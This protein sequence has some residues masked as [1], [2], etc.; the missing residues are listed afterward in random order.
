MIKVNLAKR[1]KSGFTRTNMTGGGTSSIKLSGG[2]GDFIEKM[3]DRFSRPAQSIE[4]SSAGGSKLSIM[5]GNPIVKLVFS[6]VMVYLVMETLDG[7][8][9]TEVKNVQ[10]QIDKSTAESM[11]LT[12]RLNEL[13]GYQELKNKL[14][15]DE[16]SLKTKLETLVKLMQD[17]AV[18]PK[19]LLQL[20][21]VLPDECWITEVKINE[22]QVVFQGLAS[23]LETIS[24][25][26]KNINGS[27]YL[28]DAQMK[29]ANEEKS[30]TGEL[31]L[32]KFEVT[33]VR[34]QV[35]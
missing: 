30:K 2:V 9:K 23:S 24:D 10:I 31:K 16:R 33:A 1:T 21:Q 11:L 29:S 3:K 32:Q 13:T 17:R 19:L 6:I 15:L 35:L 26:V 7:A 28:T 18:Q 5:L 22:Q 25:F 14:D 34:K 20:S 27:N 12:N 8:K 4:T